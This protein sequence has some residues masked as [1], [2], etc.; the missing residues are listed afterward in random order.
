MSRTTSS[1]SCVKRTVS[2]RRG[3]KGS[4]CAWMTASGAALPKLGH[5]LGR[6]VLGQVATIVMPDTILRWHR[7][8]VARK[9]TY[10]RVSGGRPGLQAHLRALVVRMATENPTWGHTRRS[11]TCQLASCMESPMSECSER[12]S[13]KAAPSAGN[14]CTDGRVAFQSDCQQP[15]PNGFG[16]CQGR[17]ATDWRKNIRV[18]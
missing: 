11:L 14:G 7:R 17:C 8:L 9:W 18:R 16:E 15:Y 5:R 4:D 6:R 2:S 1:R 13:H 12:I 3:S 10:V